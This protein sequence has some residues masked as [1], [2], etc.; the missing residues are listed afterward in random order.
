MAIII[1][2]DMILTKK[3]LTSRFLADEIGITEQNLSILKNGRAKGI[4]FNTL[5]KICKILECQPG[6][7]IQYKE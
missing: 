1:Q 4:R 5:D 2:L 7:I 3:K 6:D